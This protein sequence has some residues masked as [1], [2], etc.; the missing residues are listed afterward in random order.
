MEQNRI[1]T[2]NQGLELAIGHFQ[3]GEFEPVER[4]C[5]DILTGNPDCSSAWHLLGLVVWQHDNR[6]EAIQML[7]RAIAL[8]PASPDY[9]FNIGLMLGGTGCY[10]EAEEAIGQSRK[11]RPA[12]SGFVPSGSSAEQVDRYG[13]ALIPGVFSQEEIADLRNFMADVAESGSSGWAADHTSNALE[14]SPELRWVVTHP[15]LLRI[16]REAVGETY[17]LMTADFEYEK[18]AYTGW[19]TDVASLPNAGRTYH[20]GPQYLI[21]T[22]LIYLQDNHPVYGGGMDVLLGSHKT[23]ES[24]FKTSELP[25]YIPHRTGD[26]VI[27]DSRALHRATPKL[28]HRPGMADKCFISI[29]W[30]RDRGYA[31]LC[32]DHYNSRPDYVAR[33]IRSQNAPDLEDYLTAAGVNHLGNS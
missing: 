25:Y 16:V 18:N 17:V 20:L 26:V 31:S 28:F 19:H 3:R 29:R 27:L 21:V 22:T 11:L 23:K 15:G 9:F 12:Y 32:L 7:R 8:D 6:G 13:C 2:V 1:L 33:N 14:R 30:G 5:R 4:I 10:D 24:E